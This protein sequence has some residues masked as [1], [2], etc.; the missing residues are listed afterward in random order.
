MRRVTHPIALTGPAAAAIYGLD[1]FRNIIW[2]H[3]YVTS[4]KGHGGDNVQRTRHWQT[5]QHIDGELVA[6]IPLVL[7]HLNTHP[8]DLEDLPDGIN[9]QDRVE[10]AT[11][12]ARRLGHRITIPHNAHGPGDQLLRAVRKLSGTEPPTESYAETRFLQWCRSVHLHPWRQIPVT[13]NGKK[14]RI[15]FGFSLGPRY[16]PQPIR[17]HQLLFCE[18][19]SKEFHEGTFE[20]D[21][22]KRNAFDRAGFHHIGITPNQVTHHPEKALASILGAIDRTGRSHR[23]KVSFTPQPK[24]AKK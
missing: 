5:P 2:P 14:Y 17:P 15:D 20:Q 4:Y 24:T 6:T 16:R 22:E 10:L 18:L 13:I 21:S 9:P 3:R 11:E 12:H 7:R 23:R 8:H 19:N 1:G